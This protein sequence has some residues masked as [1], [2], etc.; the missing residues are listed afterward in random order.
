MSHVVALEVEEPTPTV[1]TQGQSTTFSCNFFATVC[2]IGVYNL[3]TMYYVGLR[4][5]NWKTRCGYVYEVTSDSKIM[6]ISCVS[7]QHIFHQFRQQTFF[8][9]HI[10]NKLFFNF[11]T[12]P[13]PPPQISI[14]APLRWLCISTRLVLPSSLIGRPTPIECDAVVTIWR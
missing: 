3:F 11:F 1:A 12:S 4:Q 10:L 9:G 5:E 6:L 13:P 7:G 14:G 2:C 8:S